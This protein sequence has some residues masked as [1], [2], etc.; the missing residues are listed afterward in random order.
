MTKPPKSTLSIPN[1]KITWFYYNNIESLMLYRGTWE[2]CL[3]GAESTFFT[4]YSWTSQWLQTFWNDTCELHFF[5][6]FDQDKCVL[7][8]PFYIQNS[9]KFPFIKTL[10][11]LGQGEDEACEVSSE[12][13][14]IYLHEDY[15]FLLKEL[16]KKINA[17]KFD[18]LNIRA[19][20]EN[21]HLLGLCSYLANSTS[22][23][24]GMRFTY[25]STHNSVP[26]LSKNTKS[27]LNK[28]KNKLAALNAEFI[29]VDT[30]DYDTYWQM[31]KKFHQLRWTKL[32]KNG[33]FCHEKFSQFHTDYR[34]INVDKI[35]ISAVLVENTP[36]A[37]HY[38][39]INNNTL[40]F[41]QSGWDETHY[42]NVSPSFAL[43][44]WCMN[45]NPVVLYDFMMGNTHNSYK[46]K[47]GCNQNSKMYHVAFV[48]NNIKY[49]L[50]KLIN[51]LTPN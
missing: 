34:K 14:D 37:I 12:Y 32:G 7:F 22:F 35:K 26:T 5:M 30:K 27:K 3:S 20:L 2:S 45:N 1:N 29:W 24:A 38:Y 36:I 51:K 21:S 28:C 10:S 41:Y 17:L 9:T 50:A 23:D 13:Q 46:A 47:L 4:S 33:A 6:V 42:A 11:L 40:Y 15:Q 44:V 25:S 16:A 43:H 19:L 31:M 48:R 49:T 8:A 39:F 18:H